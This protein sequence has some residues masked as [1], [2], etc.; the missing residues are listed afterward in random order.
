MPFL[1]LSNRCLELLLPDIAPGANSVADDFDIELRH[2]SNCGF[3]HAKER[4][5]KMCRQA[6]EKERRTTI[7]GWLDYIQE[8]SHRESIERKV[9]VITYHREVGRG[10][11]G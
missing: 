7:I 5:D 4:K 6:L 2:S 1:V 8:R 10:M 11:V 9:K 3:K